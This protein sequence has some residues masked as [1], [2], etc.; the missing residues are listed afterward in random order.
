M[1]SYVAAATLL[2]GSFFSFF[3][4]SYLNFIFLKGHI[5]DN[6]KCQAGGYAG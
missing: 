2:C 6:R 3:E 5:D 4:K 1:R